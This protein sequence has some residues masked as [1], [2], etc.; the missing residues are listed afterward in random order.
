MNATSTAS[1]G[2]R[3]TNGRREREPGEDDEPDGDVYGTPIHQF[4]GDD[5]PTEDEA[6]AFLV[7]R[8]LPEGSPAAIVGPPKSKKSI[9]A[10]D[11]SIS[12]ALGQPWLGEFRAKPGRVLLLL[13]EDTVPETRRRI[14]RLARG[15]GVDPRSLAGQL[16]VDATT[17]FYFDSKDDVARMRRSLDRLKPVLVVIDSLSRC[18]RADE[19]SRRDMAV[20]TTTW[21][22]LCRTYGTAIVVIHHYAKNAE[23]NRGPG[24]RMRGSGD[25]FAL[26]R[27]VVGI[28]A[29]RRD[30]SIVTTDGNLSRQAEPFGF[31]L[32][33]G[34]NPAGKKTLSLEYRGS[35]E[36]IER[37]SVD[38]RIL[39]ALKNGPLSAR[40][41]RAA[42]GGRAAVVTARSRVLETM[43]RIEQDE[44]KRWSLVA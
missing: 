18:N 16:E 29:V 36:D 31:T 41:L 17:P 12:V 24:L 33:D 35:Q 30:V 13:H 4:L 40:D 3:T 7:D 19:N 21:A 20:V 15:R 22:D 28:E 43:G 25:L 26:C 5:E 34:L 9:A 6:D 14:W 38:A 2:W 27:G 32:A 39:A 23:S 42:V 1:Y 8:L 11:M 37:A 10:L 44:E